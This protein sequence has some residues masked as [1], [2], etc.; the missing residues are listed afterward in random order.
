MLIRDDVAGDNVERIVMAPCL[1]L[2]FLKDPLTMI[3]MFHDS[4]LFIVY[5]HLLFSC[6]I[7][8]LLQDSFLLKFVRPIAPVVPPIPAAHSKRLNSLLSS[9]KHTPCRTLVFP[10]IPIRQILIHL[11]VRPTLA[12]TPAF[13]TSCLSCRE[14]STWSNNT[15]ECWCIRAI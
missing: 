1:T 12:A 7:I 15:V 6:Y 2:L 5:L 11:A 4:L 9:Y 10:Q 14:R 8:A 3:A 13:Q